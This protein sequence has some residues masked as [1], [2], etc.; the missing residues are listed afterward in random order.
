M[1][2]PKHHTTGPHVH[3]LPSG[4]EEGIDG[5]LHA[6][7]GLPLPAAA[8][9]QRQL[10]P[11]VHRG[12]AVEFGEGRDADAAFT[13][14]IRRP[15]SKGLPGNCAEKEKLHAELIMRHICLGQQTERSRAVQAS[16]A[17]HASRHPCPKAPRSQLQTLSPTPQLHPLHKRCS[18]EIRSPCKLRP[19]ACTRL[20][21]PPQSPT[22]LHSTPHPPSQSSSVADEDVRN[23]AA[24]DF[25]Q[26][27]VTAYLPEPVAAPA[28]AA[29]ET[30]STAGKQC[31]DDTTPSAS[32]RPESHL[33]RNSVNEDCK[34][35]ID[36]SLTPKRVRKKHSC[37]EPAK[38]KRQH[39]ICIPSF[40][41]FC[42]NLQPKPQTLSPF[43]Y[44]LPLV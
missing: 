4:H 23:G 36:T 26:L 44:A 10:R 33:R 16:W 37:P 5:E 21:R 14:A 30:L 3:A 2:Q 24:D 41:S 25:A 42:K 43:W 11:R 34:Q 40:S 6:I 27:V 18:H 9:P 22:P 28:W 17:A 8:H 39:S 15:I 19:A 29:A 7:Q 32:L 20:P 35:K 12:S 13:P 38:T 31:L 1:Q